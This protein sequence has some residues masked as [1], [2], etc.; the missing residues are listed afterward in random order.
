MIITKTPLRISL[1]G[2]NTDFPKYFLKHGGAVLTAAIDKYIY[3]IVKDR[4]DDQIW[5]NY[6]E[7]EIVNNVSEIK[8]DLVRES[9]KLVGI[10]KGIEI[11]FLSDIPSEGSGLGSSSAVTVGLL[12]ALY[13]Y[14]DIIMS[15]FELAKKA[16]Q[17]EIKVLKKPIGVQDQYAVTY[18]GCNMFK[19]SS[20]VTE[21][22]KL[23]DHF[24][25]T[26]KRSL[27]LFYTGKTRKA[28]NILSQMKLN[29][30]ILD[31]NKE[32]VREGLQALTYYDYY[33]FG[34]LLH[35]YWN[36]K[37]TLNKF[38]TTEF[39]DSLYQKALDAGA[40]G[41]KIVGAGGGGFLLLVVRPAFKEQ[42]RKALGLKELKFKL[43]RTG[44]EVILNI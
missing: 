36:L 13:Q 32:L 41:G 18:G 12:K 1:L 8:H 20:N 10:E 34:D 44:S 15:D 22:M 24:E 4:F 38:V 11:T 3:C 39:I 2:G 42:I 29:K 9:L 21:Q 17:I 43:S 14:K 27:M 26:F 7:K 28:E 33:M 40:I 23:S 37:K 30:N 31:K 35:K 25:E 16:C 5:I 19:F 6:S